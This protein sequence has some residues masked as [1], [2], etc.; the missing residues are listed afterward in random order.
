MLG[1][2]DE[3]VAAARDEQ[4]KSEAVLAQ[5]RNA[6]NAYQRIQAARLLLPKAAAKHSGPPVLS[7]RMLLAD[8]SPYLFF[9]EHYMLLLK[10]IPEN[11]STLHNCTILIT[12]SNETGDVAENVHFVEEMKAGETYF[13]VYGPGANFGDGRRIARQAVPNIRHFFVSCWCDEGMEEHVPF[14]LTDA[15]RE[16]SAFLQ[17]KEL[18]LVGKYQPAVPGLFGKNAGVAV[19]MN[20]QSD[21][22]PCRIRVTL[23]NGSQEQTLWWKLDGW[24]RGET[25]ELLSKDFT[26]TPKSMFLRLGFPDYDHEHFHFQE[27]PQ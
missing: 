27:I 6:A 13:A 4:Q 11:G 2:V 22:P 12:V 25:K 1:Q 3:A 20:A 24:R 14:V 7:G 19:T 8:L 21:L 9:P 18:T 17:C 23:N 5:A 15:H 16:Q 10:A 26:I